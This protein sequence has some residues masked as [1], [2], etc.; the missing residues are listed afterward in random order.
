MKNTFTK[1]LEKLE[2]MPTRTPEEEAVLQ[3]LNALQGV[4][5]ARAPQ[6]EIDAAV[7]AV[8]TAEEAVV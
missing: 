6:A 7:K 1:R 5:E 3:A 2:A 8:E 4:E